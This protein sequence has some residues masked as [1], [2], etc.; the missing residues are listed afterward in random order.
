MKRT[1]KRNHLAAWRR[2][3]ELSQEQ[4]AE[5]ADTSKATISRL[6]AGK[7]GLSQKWL[8]ILAPILDATPSQL[9]EPPEA[10]SI[11]ITGPTVPLID[12][13][14]AGHWNEVADPYSKG[15][16]KT[17]IPRLRPYGPRAFALELDGPS[18]EPEY[19]DKDIIVVDPDIEAQP[20]DDV[21]ARIDDENLATFKRL[22]IKGYDGRGK[23]EI[24]LVPLN[25][26]WPVLTMKKSGRIVGVAVDLIRRL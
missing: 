24:E 19:H 4:L 14:R 11:K 22:R 23:P 21:V 12:T 7:R 9:L 8:E 6:E 25:P 17:K 20:G 5:L 16:A 10:A 13:V 2:A 18:M 3:R 1:T 26:N 15:D